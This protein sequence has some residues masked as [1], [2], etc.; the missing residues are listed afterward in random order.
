MVKNK[1]PLPCIEDLFDQLREATGFSKIDLRSRYHQIEIKNED[2][3][4]T[5]FRTRYGHYEFVVMSF[6]LTNAPAV[7]M[8]LMNRV[9]KECLDSFVIVF[10]EDILIYS[11]T[12]L[13]HQEHL[14]KALTILRE[15]KLYVNF[16]KCKF[17]LRQV[18]FLG[19]VVS[20]DGILV[21]PTKIEAVTKWKRSTTI[22]EIR[23]FLGFAGYYRR[24]VQ[25][26]ARVASPLTQLTKKGVP[27]V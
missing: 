3:P 16:S 12:D 6:G 14:R 20:K 4:K 22:I 21:D 26:F 1:Y 18:S 7:F 24:F 19:H 15:N 17:W 11:K 10:I 9:F 27:F 23:S 2:I 13:E 5:S 8:E 25:D